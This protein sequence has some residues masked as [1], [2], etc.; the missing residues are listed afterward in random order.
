MRCDTVLPL[1]FPKRVGWGGVEGSTKLCTSDE[2]VCLWVLLT[3]QK[4]TDTVKRSSMWRSAP[5][6]HRHFSPL[7][8]LFHGTNSED[9]F[10]PAV[11][12]DGSRPFCVY[13]GGG[14]VLWEGL[15]FITQ[16]TDKRRTAECFV[17]FALLSFRPTLQPPPLFWLSPREAVKRK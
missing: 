3:H 12:F 1:R 2:Q 8:H 16:G 6:Q 10:G 4:P 14:A 9:C 17:I 15:T 13:W 5:C 7:V 11:L